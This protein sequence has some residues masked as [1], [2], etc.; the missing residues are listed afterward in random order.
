MSFDQ[1]FAEKSGPASAENSLIC[2][3]AICSQRSAERKI[4][5][6]DGWAISTFRHA[7]EDRAKGWASVLTRF[8]SGSNG[9]IFDT[10][11]DNR[12]AGLDG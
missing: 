6:L 2:F 4:G 5:S 3:V 1:T 12:T 7:S 10:G 8:I 9:E 11:R